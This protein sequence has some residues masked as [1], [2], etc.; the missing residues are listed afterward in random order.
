[1]VGSCM[2]PP[3]IAHLTRHC[4]PGINLKLRVKMKMATLRQVGIRGSTIFW[5]VWPAMFTPGLEV[6]DHQDPQSVFGSGLITMPGHIKTGI[7]DNQIQALGS[8]VLLFTLHEQVL[9]MIGPVMHRNLTFVVSL[10]K[11]FI[12]L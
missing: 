12:C 8:P 5:Q 3:A 1:M 6:T 2:N 11:K 4:S 9:G 10:F 7:L